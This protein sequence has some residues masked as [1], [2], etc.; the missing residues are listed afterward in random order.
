MYEIEE[1]L[2]EQEQTKKFQCLLAWQDFYLQ[3]NN[4]WKAELV[5][6]EIA[7]FYD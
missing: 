5:G 1:H 4:N 2:K 6:R 3:A 7:K